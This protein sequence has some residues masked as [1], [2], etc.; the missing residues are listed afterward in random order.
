MSSKL[1]FLM[2]F[3]II[4]LSGCL[5]SEYTPVEDTA[6]GEPATLEPVARTP[7]PTG[8]C[9]EVSAH[10]LDGLEIYVNGTPT[11]VQTPGRVLLEK[12][13]LVYLSPI[14]YPGIQGFLFVEGEVFKTERG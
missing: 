11:G 2:F 1:Y 6:Q 13:D 7:D 14:V 4:T 9:C 3:A 12:G 10:F 8:P 5:P